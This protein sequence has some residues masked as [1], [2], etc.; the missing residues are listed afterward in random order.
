MTTADWALVISICS[1]AVS[2]AGFVWNV[3]SKFIYPKPDLRVHFSM[4][5]FIGDGPWRDPFLSLSITNHGPIGCTITH[6]IIDI[7]DRAQR[8]KRRGLINP[9]RDISASIEHTDGPFTNLPKK[10]DVGEEFSLRF[11]SG[12][13]SFLEEE[14]DRVG[15][16]DTF[17]RHHWCACRHVKKVQAEYF[18][19]R[20]AG[21]LPKLSRG[22]GS[23]VDERQ[24]VTIRRL[25][26]I[27]L[28]AEMPSKPAGK[29]S[30]EIRAAELAPKA[31]EKIIDPAAPP[32][33]RAQRRRRLTKGPSEF[34]EDRVD[35]P[36]ANRK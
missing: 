27:A 24:G 8:K 28:K 29:A 20:D 25:V 13:N 6:A 22:R 18:K 1:A 34:R 4:M 9:L 15:V 35:L 33:E 32:E 26:E 12:E 3:W 2:L 36:K 23:S 10:I 14:V 19:M 16:I 17:G 7:D 21:D 5:G 11:W 31:I 30:N